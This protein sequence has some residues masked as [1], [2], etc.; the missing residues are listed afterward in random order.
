MKCKNEFLLRVTLTVLYRATQEFITSFELGDFDTI[1]QS[2]KFRDQLTRYNP[3]KLFIAKYEQIINPDF[4]IVSNEI[5][6]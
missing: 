4:K 5:N 6:K 2:E 1:R 3:D